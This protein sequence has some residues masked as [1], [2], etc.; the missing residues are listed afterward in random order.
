MP[1][2]SK[3]IID[4]Y[5]S[6]AASQFILHGNISDRVLIPKS[7][8][9]PERMG[10]LTEYL[11]ESLLVKFDVVLAYD[12][13]NG[14]RVEKGG[15]TFAQ[16]PA[17]KD[18]T[19]PVAPREAVHVLS[20]YLRYCGNLARLKPERT[21]RVAVLIINAHLIVPPAQG[22]ANYELS[23]TA[24]QLRDW[25]TDPLITGGHCASFLL[26]E[27]LNDL[28]PLLSNNPQ[29]ARVA[30]P[31]PGKD[32]L[33]PAL[34]H[35]GTLYPKPLAPFAADPSSIAAALAGATLHSIETMLQLRQHGG[36]ELTQADLISI[37][38]DLVEKDANGLIE[39]LKPDRT[40]DD[41]HGVEAI[42]TWLR[43]D[44]ALWQ[45]GELAAMPMGYLFCGPVGTG[46][47]FLVECLAGEAGVPVVKMKNFRDRWVGSTE[48][49]LEKIFRLL[50]ALGRCIVFIDEAD[51]AL[52]RR[53][54]DSGDSGVSGRIYGMMAEQMS[55][56]RNRGRILWALATSRPDLVEIDL[57]RPGR[58]DVKIPI[59]PTSS[60]AES[61]ALTRA[62]CKRKGLTL[63]DAM[64]EAVTPLMPSLLTPGA[65]EALAVKTFRIL[66][67]GTADP[68]AAL[69]AALRDY[70][71]PVPLEVIESQIRL[72]I[73]E[74]T[75]LSFVPA[76]WRS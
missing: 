47:T 26:T 34:T 5:E 62:L 50:E 68:V 63:P 64:P 67:T 36:A 56:S 19:L 24:S 51:Q 7:A 54:A 37:K 12:L 23:A 61:Y 21:V 48:G 3:E 28:H 57:K 25:A 65:A 76:M 75:D 17:W 40:L 11:R 6:G 55:N 32:A 15:E 14:A 35:L 73:A 13:G 43:Q 33:G 49:N 69:T 39:F 29:S 42:K 9:G 66:K 59:F 4:L 16:W 27:N 8:A 30:V 72:A 74:A 22:S 31:L 44:I 58:I 70:Q 52:G 10:S 60:P 20:H 71:A 53:N 45:Q 41:L 2:W 1:P 46:K 38:K 18:K